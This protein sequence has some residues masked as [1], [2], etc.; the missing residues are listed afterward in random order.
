MPAFQQTFTKSH[1]GKFNLER[2]NV[3]RLRILAPLETLFA[4]RKQKAEKLLQKWSVFLKEGAV[5]KI[6]DI[7]LKSINI[8]LT[9]VSIQISSKKINQI[10]LTKTVTF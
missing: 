4:S 9:E 1:H 3:L 5:T 6:A 8:R 10:L 2:L 7:L